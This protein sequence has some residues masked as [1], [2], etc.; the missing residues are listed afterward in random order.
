MCAGCDKMCRNKSFKDT[1]M[2]N[3]N[4][5]PLFLCRLWQEQIIRSKIRMGCSNLKGHFHSMK[6]IDSSACLCGFINETEFYCFL[7]CPL[8]C[9]IDL[10]LH[11]KML[12]DTY[13]IAPFTLRTLL[14]GNKNLN[15]TVSKSLVTG[16]LRFMKDSN[17]FDP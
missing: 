17:R 11:F 14:Y 16:T 9:S 6:L 4:D 5:N 2:A 13:I 10:E 8:I 12:L 1:L 3:T 7:A 15:L